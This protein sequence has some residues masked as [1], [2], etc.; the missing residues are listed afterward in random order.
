MKAGKAIS[1][2]AFVHNSFQKIL[3][4]PAPFQPQ[5]QA[6]N[7]SESQPQIQQPLSPSNHQHTYIEATDKG[8]SETLCLWGYPLLIGPKIPFLKRKKV[9]YKMASGRKKVPSWPVNFS[10]SWV[11]RQARIRVNHFDVIAGG[12]GDSAHKAKFFQLAECTLNLVAGQP[13]HAHQFCDLYATAFHIAMTFLVAVCCF[14]RSTGLR[15]NSRIASSSRSSR[16]WTPRTRC[17]FLAM[18]SRT[19]FF[20]CTQLM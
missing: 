20:A 12:S 3:L 18:R 7:Q 2:T 19:A 13:G 10:G 6:L 17:R 11:K 8:L 16:S 15:F 9:P 14:S 5:N 1:S 4:I